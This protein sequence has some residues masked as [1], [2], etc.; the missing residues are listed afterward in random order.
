MV[1]LFC[2][3]QENIAQ[4]FPRAQQLVRDA[5]EAKDGAVLV[6]CAQGISRSTTIVCSVVFAGQASPVLRP[7]VAAAVHDWRGG[8]DTDSSDDDDGG[9]GTNGDGDGKS[10]DPVG[11]AARKRRGRAPE[12][13][14]RRA[15]GKRKRRA[16]KEAE[17]ARILAGAVLETELLTM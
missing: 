9:D 6:H 15:R 2:V 13:K 16:Q 4:F 7:L 3:W 11:R 17:R 5:R 1:C 8:S 10:A 12:D 14:R